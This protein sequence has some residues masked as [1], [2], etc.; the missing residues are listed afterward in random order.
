MITID[1][2]IDRI[3][4]RRAKTPG[5][6]SLL[7]GISGI[8]GSGKGYIAAQLEAHLAQH[9]VTS[10]VV[11]VDGWLNLPEKRFDPEAP[12]E[13]FYRQ[14]IRFEEFFSN[15]IVPLRDHRSI[16]LISDFAEETAAQYRKH[17]YDIRNVD[18]VLVEGIFLFKN[19]Y[20]NFFDLRIWVECSFATALVRA[21]ERGQEGLSLPKTIAAYQSTYFPAQRIHFERDNPRAAAD[22]VYD[23]DQYRPRVLPL[24]SEG[25]KRLHFRLAR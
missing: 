9:A 4:D 14:A 10:V 24:T 2:I 20:Q 13:N 22:L 11:N 15:L 21:I 6:R 17:L 7:V 19:A 23:N 3:I 25:P 5:N 1:H 16:R 18:V 12:A 8:D